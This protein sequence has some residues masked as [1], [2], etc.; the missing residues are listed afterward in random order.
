MR[1][2][3]QSVLDLL[4]DKDNYS[5]NPMM[6]KEGHFFGFH[7]VNPFSPNELYVLSNK[8]EIPL[9]MP[10]SQDPLTVGYWD[11]AFTEY[12]SI[13]QTHAWNYHKGCRLQWLGKSNDEF[14]FNDITDGNLGA[15]IYSIDNKSFKHIS[16]PI[17]TISPCG[18]YA[19]SFSY[20]RLN[21]FMPGYSYEY[22]DNPYFE[23]S[24]SNKTGIF[25]VDLNS[26][27]QNL[28]VSLSRLASLA[29]ERSME[30]ANHFVTHTEFSPDGERIAFL[31]RWTHD[32]P[33]KRYSRLVTCKLDGSEIQISP[34]SGMVSHYDWDSVHGILAYCQIDGI[35][36]HYIFSDYT[37]KKSM[38]VAPSLNSDGHQSY[39]HNSSKFVTDTYP[40]K[41]RHAKLYLVDIE[42]GDSKEIAD[43]KSPK[44]YQSPT[45]YKNWACDLHPRVSPSGR[46]VSFDSV[47]GG[48]RSFCIMPLNDILN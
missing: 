17:D 43:L 41:R 35:D 34:T 31:Y 5:I 13:K 15:I 4:P 38:R 29:P 9:R 48:E 32:D 19:T 25:L 18:R 7:D 27:E 3:Y 30:G 36:G 1:N 10:S 8:L 42:S 26:N 37:M 22:K 2:I 28:I 33:D 16:Y 24:A 6:V 44:K 11:T 21:R 47:H 14:I 40:D 45:L 20:E 23:E 39:V 12:K 46:F